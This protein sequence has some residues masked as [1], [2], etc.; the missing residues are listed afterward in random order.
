MN[1]LTTIGNKNSSITYADRPTVKVIVRNGH[2]KILLLNDGLL[3]G[4]G[5]ERNESNEQALGREVSEECGMTLK[6]ITPLG[7]VVQYRDYLAK[8]YIVYG[9]SADRDTTV[10]E[11]NPQDIGEMNFEYQWLS[12]D[13]A[14]ALVKK[15]IAS[16]ERVKVHDDTQQGP[17]YNRKTTLALLE[18]YK[19][20]LS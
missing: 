18:Q 3:P 8:R 12:T 5:V 4:G 11:A 2:G 15:S 16:L 10:T 9:Y 13:A 14:I 6:N 17:L 7:A 19:R 1:T 20:S